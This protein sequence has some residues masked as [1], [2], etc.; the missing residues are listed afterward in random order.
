[1]RV[2]RYVLLAGALTLGASCTTTRNDAAIAQELNDAA[3]EIGGLKSDLAQLQDQIDSL[4]T[5]V[6]KH[7]TTIS[8]IAAANNIPIA[9]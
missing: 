5:I 7:D 8:H 9:R 6:A 4:R 2:S 3:T 1:M